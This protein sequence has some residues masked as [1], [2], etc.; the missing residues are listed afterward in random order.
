MQVDSLITPQIGEGATVRVGSDAYPYTIIDISDSGKTIYLREDKV[1]R[2]DNNGMSELQEYNYFRNPEGK[3]IKATRR[4][5]GSW[6]TTGNNCPVS[7]GIR[8]RFYDFSF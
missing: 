8:C 1:E 5:N 2:I 4:K 3:E 6:K 7:I